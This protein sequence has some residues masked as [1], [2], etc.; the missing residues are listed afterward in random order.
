MEWQLIVAMLL[1]GGALTYLLYSVWQAV[2]GKKSCG[3][4]GCDA[5]PPSKE[6]ATFVPVDQVVPRRAGKK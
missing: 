5:K 3:G 2:R 4:C 6:Q 1:V